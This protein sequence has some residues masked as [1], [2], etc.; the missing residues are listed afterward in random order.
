MPMYNKT[1]MTDFH[2]MNFKKITY[3]IFRKNKIK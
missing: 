3:N 1:E 2:A